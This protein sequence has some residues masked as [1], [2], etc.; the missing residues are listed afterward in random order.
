MAVIGRSR[1]AVSVIG[2]GVGFDVCVGMR[3][4]LRG[5]AMNIEHLN[6]EW[7]ELSIRIILSIFYD[8][9][10]FM[11]CWCLEVVYIN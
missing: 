9:H 7:R 6:G 8:S 5:K 4:A 1:Q 10:E 2:G 3:H 11:T